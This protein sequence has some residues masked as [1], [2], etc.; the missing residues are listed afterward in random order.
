MLF[1]RIEK[2]TAPLYATSQF[3]DLQTSHLLLQNVE[4]SIL[5]F[6]RD[7]CVVFFNRVAKEGIRHFLNM[8]LHKGMHALELL[9]PERVLLLQSIYADVLEGKRHTTENSYTQPDGKVVHFENNFL[10]AYDENQEI[11]GIIVLSKETT[12]K[13]KAQQIIQDSE[14]RLQFA[15]E[16]THQ[17]A[18][19]WNLKTNEVVFSSSYKKLYGFGDNELKNDV[20]EWL[21]RIHPDD[22]SKM[23]VSVKEH[24][25]SP[26]PIYDSRYRIRA[27]DGSYRW[28]LAK[29][30]LIREEESGEPIRMIG[31]HTDIT[32]VVDKETKLR[33]FNERFNY[34]MKATNEMLWEWD[35][36]NNRIFRSDDG[37]RRVYGISDNHIIE[38]IDQWLLRVHPDDA[39]K[40]VSI[41]KAIRKAAHNDTFELEYRFRR[42]D[43]EYNHIYDRGIAIE[44]E[45]GKLVRIIGSAQDI[46]ERKRLEKEL[47]NAE[48][49]YQ[50]LIHQATIDSQEKERA[51]IGKELHDNINQVLTTTK[52]YLDL[53][54]SNTEIRE[55]L[56]GKSLKNINGVIKEIR[57]LSRSLMDPSIGDLGLL[58]SLYDL[59]ENI[60]LTKKVEI[61]LT[62]DEAIEDFLDANQKLA[63][64]RIFQESLNNVLRHARATRVTINLSLN[65]DQLHAQISDNGI[66]FQP[67]NARKGAGLKN[68]Q[69]RIYLINGT[70]QIS[71]KPGEG[72]SLFIQFPI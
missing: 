53:A 71:S 52:L 50:R 21:T 49:E 51:E 54:L 4:E 72:C 33:Q 24:L 9:Q 18:W 14:E 43:G 38:E 16:A 57:H 67:E 2:M 11:Q 30:R 68:I 13:K 6:N 40:T 3:S 59:V 20:S 56:I 25:Q 12:E 5:M 36:E 45:E 42:D 7:L 34:I 39:G 31:T 63:L 44:N 62:A 17:G 27:K 41:L 69:N 28:V 46:S 22:Q 29:G 23:M 61:Q 66:G 55:D 32:D 70:L 19:D 37:L 60:H 35:L 26:D 15:L 1:P 58:A 8:D 48:L 10:P 47:L 65:S 64:F